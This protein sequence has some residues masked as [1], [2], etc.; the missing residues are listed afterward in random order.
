MSKPII[1]THQLTKQYGEFTAV[2]N[3]ELSIN[4]GEIVGFLGPNGA[5]KTTTLLM[6]MGLSVPT[7]GTAT[8]GG[9]DVVEESK[10]VRQIAGM[11][12]EG[13]G[14]Y[15]DLTARQNLQYIGQLND[16]P[17]DEVDNR[18]DELLEAVDLVKWADTKVEKFSRGMK[19]RLGISEVLIKQPK[20]AF[21]DEPT[22]GLDPKSTK[23]LRDILL[24]L[25]K[26]QG[27]T[28]FLS[29]HLLHE[30]QQTCQRVLI[31]RRGKL[32]AADTIANLSNNL[33]SKDM[34]SIEFELTEIDSDLIQKLN[35]VSGVKSVEQQNH[36]LFVNLENGNV[37][38]VSETITKHGSIILL[39][40]PRT[41]SLEEIFLDYYKE[42]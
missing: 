14:Y 9:Y 18:I 21:F 3:L 22:L 29:S 27:L 13:S 39:M 11:M 6:L 5:G 8:V 23:E 24:K 2:N 40:K 32:V 4:E 12:P 16:I 36:K 28:I 34:S 35:D 31:I 37:R 10:Q 26:E 33:L 25:N 19:Q 20:I 15:E 41:F 7:S 1:E 17:K 38:E 30:V 42:D